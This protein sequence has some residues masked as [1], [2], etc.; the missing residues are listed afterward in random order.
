[1]HLL[2]FSETI[3]EKFLDL[4]IALMQMRE[5]TKLQTI[6]LYEDPSFTE[7]TFAANDL[8]NEKKLFGKDIWIDRLPA[9]RA[10]IERYMQYLIDQILIGSDFMIEDLFHEI[11]LTTLE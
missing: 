7:L 9:N 4:P 10:N 5:I 3:T 2:I 1:M 8:E 6:G 11:E